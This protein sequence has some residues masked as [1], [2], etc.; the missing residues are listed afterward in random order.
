M[1]L[2]TQTLI[3]ILSLT[4]LT[5][6]IALF[7]QY[8][9][10]N[11]PYHGIGLWLI[12]SILM[13]LGFVFMPFVSV[14]SLQ[15]LAMIANPLVVL[16]HVFLYVGLI[17]FFDQREKSWLI[18]V[19][20]SLFLIFYYYFMFIFNDLSSRSAVINGA[21]AVISFL[22]VLKIFVGQDKSISHATKFTGATFLFYA[23]LLTLRFIIAIRSPQVHSYV[24]QGFVL[25]AGF[26]MS[27]FMS[28]LWTFGLILMINQ[29]LN[30]DNQ[31]EKE[32][33]QLIF[34]TGP[35]AAMIIRLEDSALIDMNAGFTSL[36]G[37]SREEALN[38][39]PSLATIWRSQAAFDQFIHTL[40]SEESC[41]NMEELFSSKSGRNFYGMISARQIVI[42]DVL[43][44]ITIIRDITKRK[45]AEQ[46]LM[47]SEEQYRSILNASPDDITITDL[48]GYILIMSPAAKDMFGYSEDVHQYSGMHILDFILPE[49]I[50]RAKASI[51]KMHHDGASRP[52]AYRG[53]R[54]DGSI[55]DIE[56]NSGFVRNTEGEPIRMVFIVRDVTERKLAEQQIQALVQQLEI[57]KNT[58]QLHAMTDSLTGLYNRRY[59]DLVLKTEFYRLKRSNMTLSLIML[60]IDHFKKYNDTYGHLSGDQ[61]LKKV[62]HT[63]KI[64]VGRTTD[65]VARYGGEE[66][67]VIL[68]ETD[69]QGAMNVAERIRSS[70]EAL[71]V[72]HA[73][74]D[75]APY[76]TVSLGVVSVNPAHVL[77]PQY[78]VETVDKALYAA[79]NSGRNRIE[80]MDNSRMS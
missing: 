42:Q 25:K 34:N 7:I 47:E 52:S 46:A 21:L 70:I 10:E 15:F 43:H 51:L 60:D 28:N 57:E 8:S 66:F 14:E 6:V 31:L 45:E 58:A 27:T 74:S 24:D 11:R 76:V 50:D 1:I 61:C 48:D 49:D 2:D 59:F 38:Q 73:A 56:M 67:M 53:V 36:F 71:K 33:M 39:Q 68:P 40:R 30:K 62:S 23:L 26:I 4:L 55:F 35:D 79:K 29:R 18:V 77:T 75:T 63:L 64:A 78:I 5:Q 22:I 37:Y 32:K 69:A 65:T 9:I 13:A 41:E 72:V 54:Q 80:V 17:R 20:Y 12:G 16:G 44:S 19:F 3:F